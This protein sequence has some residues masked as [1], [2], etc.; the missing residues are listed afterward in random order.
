MNSKLEA[1]KER[2]AMSTLQTEKPV[3]LKNGLRLPSKISLI[4]TDK[5]LLQWLQ[6]VVINSALW[7]SSGTHEVSSN[8]ES[9]MSCPSFI[10]CPCQRILASVKTETISRQILA[11]SG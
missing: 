11:G 6:I 8:K 7:Q 1:K 2:N 9:L 4:L 10:L 5:T 3:E